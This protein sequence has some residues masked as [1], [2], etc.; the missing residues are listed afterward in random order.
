MINFENFNYK[1]F[2]KIALA[3]VVMV[4]GLSYSYP[5][6]TRK[7]YTTC[8]TCHYN[9]SGAGA[10][11]PYGRII[12][13]Q[14]YGT[15]NDFFDTKVY[16]G[17]NKWLD[18]KVI[19]KGF[20]ECSQALPFLIQ[21]D[22]NV[23][24]TKLPLF[25]SQVMMRAVQTTFDTPQYKKNQ[26][27]RMQVDFELGI[28]P[29]DW[30][31]IG[32]FGPRLDSA[33]LG[34]NNYSTIDVRRF[35]GGYVTQELAFKVGKFF[36]EYGINHA[37]HNIPT[38]KGLWFQHNE[39]PYM[40]QG[41][42]F[43]NTWDFTLGYLKGHK[44]TALENKQ[45][46]SGTIAY[47]PEGNKR[48]GISALDVKEKSSASSLPNKGSSYGVFAQIGAGDYWYLLS[49]WDRKLTRKKDKVTDEILGYTESGYEIYSGVNPY[50]AVEY[51]KDNKTKNTATTPEIGLQF[52]P[53]T[54]TEFVLQYGKTFSK[55]GDQTQ[56]TK[57][58]FVMGNFYF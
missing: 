42:S 36:P 22:C 48:F 31:L 13:T 20:T 46:P 24:E 9:P 27:R 4:S 55:I 10:L 8:A 25:V 45:G 1:F 58:G 52:H 18:K 57:Q 49:E 2:V 14:V 30:Q 41:T 43:S 12:S 50:F 19:K 3:S 29:G 38:R 54:H 15:F 53:I 21:F 6:M 37:N 17:L 26:V 5:T 35:W 11:T 44:D 28:A 51:K 39:E 16:G 23:G 7:G 34:K 47:K 33:I 40:A 56:T 32:T